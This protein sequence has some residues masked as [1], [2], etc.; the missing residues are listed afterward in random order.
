MAEGSRLGKA[1][2]HMH[3]TF[4]D[5]YQTVG[6]ILTHV[7]RATDLDVIAITDHDCI[8]G[9]LVPRD[10]IAREQRL[11]QVIV[12]AEISTADGHLLALNIEHVIPAG[13][14]MDETIIAVHEQGGVAVAAH[15]LSR[16][17]SSASIE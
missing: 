1:D 2:L 16:W 11:I 14:S 15:P 3:S 13:L 6:D 10:L 7:E 8:D 17:C 12:G 4:S 9:A 5:G